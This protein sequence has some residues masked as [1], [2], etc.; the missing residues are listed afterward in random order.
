MTLALI[1]CFR[2]QLFIMCPGQDSRD[3]ED[4][5]DDGHAHPQVMNSHSQE[6]VAKRMQKVEDALAFLEKHFE[7]TRHSF[8][9]C[10]K[11]T[12]ADNLKNI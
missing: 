7:S 12:V 11:R 1:C 4:R 5:N 2:V 6:E 8:D 3:L 9:I 10:T